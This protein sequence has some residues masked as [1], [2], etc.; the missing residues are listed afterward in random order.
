MKHSFGAATTS[1]VLAV[2]GALVL[3][4]PGC[5][6]ATDL[7]AQ[8]KEIFETGVAGL[9]CTVCH[10]ED[11]TTLVGPVIE[12]GTVQMVHTALASVDAMSTLS[13]SLPQ[14]VAVSAYLQSLSQVSMSRP[15][16]A[17]EQ[18]GGALYES[19]EGK[20]GCA[21]CHGHDQ[22]AL[23]APDLTGATVADVHAV[24]GQIEEMEGVLLTLPQMVAVAAYLDYVA[25]K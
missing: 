13:L 1:G 20:I 21:D 10:G 8:G 15:M 12:G 16:T 7:V 23:V 22:T 17:L 25:A 9:P 14:M 24:V 3:G 2:L 5:A 18:Q 6:Q 4:Y 19:S 11:Q